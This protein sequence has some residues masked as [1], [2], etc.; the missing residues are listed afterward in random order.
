MI[1]CHTVS[2]PPGRKP[3]AILKFLIEWLAET[4]V[5]VNVTG[6]KRI[7]CQNKCFVQ[8]YNVT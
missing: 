8:F 1:S 3:G 7:S 4:T 6:Q 5:Q 2:R